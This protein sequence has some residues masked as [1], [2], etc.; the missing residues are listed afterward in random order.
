MRHRT[1]KDLIA[2]MIDEERFENNRERLVND[3]I[4]EGLLRSPNV[5][6]AMQTVPR[7]EFLPEPVKDQ[8]YADLPLPIGFGQTISA[9]HMVA[10]MAEAL[11]LDVGQ[12]ILEVGTGSGYHAAVLAEIVSPK[13][14]EKQGHVYTTEIVIG[15]AK[16]AKKTLERLGYAE[17]VT[18]ICGDGSMGY[19]TCAPY[20]R[21]LVTASAPTI[22]KP[23]IEQLKIG[24]LLIIPVG[25]LHFF[26]ELVKIRK[27]SETKTSS[28]NLG[29]VAFVPLTGKYGWATYLANG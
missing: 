7:E 20:D 11:E 27:E 18:V 10:I 9:P 19:A 29:G 15:L 1:F 28:K 16:S 21:V 6:R 26:Q 25:G 4:A 12:K 13:D 8:A 3:L 22:P 17:R 2:D 24:G 5:I 14:C 23:L